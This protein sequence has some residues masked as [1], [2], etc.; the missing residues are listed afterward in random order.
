MTKMEAWKE[1]MHRC[2]DPVEEV[3]ARVKQ[4]KLFIKFPASA[5]DEIKPGE[6]EQEIEKHIRCHQQWIRQFSEDPN[7]TMET[8]K[9]ILKHQQRNN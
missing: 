9:N 1:A 5:G 4:M 8:V 3:E 7:G 6:E 2:G